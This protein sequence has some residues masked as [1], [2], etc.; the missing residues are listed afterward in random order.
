MIMAYYTEEEL[1]KIGFKKLGKNVKISDKASLYDAHLIEVGENSRIDDF[2]IISGN[3][4][5][6]KYCHITPGCLIA[7]GAPGVYINDFCTMAYGVKI[8]AQSDDY[9]GASLVNSLIPKRYKNEILEK[10][11]LESH[12]IIG[13]GSVIMPGV[14]VAEGCSVGAMSLVNK[15]TLAWGVYYG[16]PVS[17]KKE[18]SRKMLTLLD[19][20]LKGINNDSI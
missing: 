17:R 10:V 14:V 19:E 2:C 3:V 16:I 8:F 20:F 6:G 5:I 9:S 13:A 11:E 1:D 4:S 15:S 12:V 18:R 7:G